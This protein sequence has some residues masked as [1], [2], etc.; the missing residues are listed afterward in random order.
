MIFLKKWWDIH[1][2]IYSGRKINM[3]M[4]RMGTFTSKMTEKTSN[5]ITNI[6][7]NANFLLSDIFLKYIIC[8]VFPV[9]DVFVADA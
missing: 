6:H 7:N 2:W 9:M 5:K 1:F 3:N 4:T 8:A